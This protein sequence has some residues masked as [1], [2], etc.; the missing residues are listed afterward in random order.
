MSKSQAIRV[1]NRL[2]SLSKS[3]IILMINVTFLTLI[4]V[5]TDPYQSL[6]T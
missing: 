3:F 4:L 6:S 5:G 1:I 2:A